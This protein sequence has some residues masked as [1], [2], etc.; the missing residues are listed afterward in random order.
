MDKQKFIQEVLKCDI[1]RKYLA[2]SM[3]NP[4]KVPRDYRDIDGKMVAC[5]ITG[6]PYDE[7]VKSLQDQEDK[8]RIDF[9]KEYE[10]HI[11][12]HL[13]QISELCEA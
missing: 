12:A 9:R 3:Y 4:I 11:T 2:F 8:K 7:Y 1:C 13:K 6:K 5:T 10:E